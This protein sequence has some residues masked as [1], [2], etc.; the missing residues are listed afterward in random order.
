MRIRFLA[1][2]MQRDVTDLAFI[3]MSTANIANHEIHLVAFDQRAHLADAV[4]R[5]AEL[6]APVHQRHAIRHRMQMERPVQR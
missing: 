4:G 6:V 1:F 2:L 5:G 3:A